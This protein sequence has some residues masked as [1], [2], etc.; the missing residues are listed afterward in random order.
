[1][2]V[3]GLSLGTFFGFLVLFLILMAVTTYIK[4]YVYSKAGIQ[5]IR[6]GLIAT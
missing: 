2:K 5:P 1:M 6:V 4:A 3:F